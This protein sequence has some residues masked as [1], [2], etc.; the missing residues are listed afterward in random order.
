MTVVPIVQREYDSIIFVPICLY[1]L[2]L[3]QLFY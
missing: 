3:F 1:H 2:Q